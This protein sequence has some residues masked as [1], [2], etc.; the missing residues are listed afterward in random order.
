MRIRWHW[1]TGMALAYTA[2]ALSTLGFVV[3][4]M[5]RPATLVSVEYYRQALAHDRRLEAE[6]NA[7]ALGPALDVHLSADRTRVVL[8]LPGEHSPVARGTVT[9]Y[10][11]S[12]PS[13]DRVVPLS[14]DANGAQRIPL[15]GLPTGR[16]RLL[17]EWSAEGRP[18]Y[19]E[20][21]FETGERR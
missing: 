20:Q 7:R 6:A 11:P 10:R 21:A 16:W 2:F 3:F 4:A 12:D 9:L 1:G 8:Q 17:L 19:V 13:A 18:Y 15:E 14:L 5:S